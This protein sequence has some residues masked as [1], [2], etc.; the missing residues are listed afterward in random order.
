MTNNAFSVVIIRDESVDEITSDPTS[1]FNTRAGSD[2]E[3][4]FDSVSVVD[5]R[6]D[7]TDE[8]TSNSTFIVD[9][10]S[11]SLVVGKII[12]NSTSVINIRAAL[13]KK[14][15]ENNST[16]INFNSLP[17]VDCTRLNDLK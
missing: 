11:I 17:W 9:T 8:I 7:S 13:L 10:R 4:M 5:I 14:R 1:M 12:L 15:N 2:G 6:I 16:W 3:T